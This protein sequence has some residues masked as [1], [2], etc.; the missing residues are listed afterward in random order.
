MAT[1]IKETPFLRG[2]DA[3]NFVRKNRNVKKVSKKEKEI[4]VSNYNLLI[5]IAQ[6]PS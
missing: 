3:E 4:I 1:P 6:F 2:K 5:E